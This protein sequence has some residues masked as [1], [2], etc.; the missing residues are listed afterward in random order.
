MAAHLTRF[1]KE[2]RVIGIVGFGSGGPDGWR[3]EWRN[4]TAAETYREVPIEHISRR[5]N[6]PSSKPM[7]G[8][9]IQNRS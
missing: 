1:N 7:S 6:I 2:T 5:S 9:A 4:K 3:M 8:A